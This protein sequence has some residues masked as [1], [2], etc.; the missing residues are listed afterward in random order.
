MNEERR[1]SQAGLNTFLA[2][3]YAFMGA[4]VGVSAVVAFILNKYYQYE[5]LTFFA[6]HRWV[7]W[8]L[9]IAQLAIAWT[10]SMRIDRTPAMTA[11]GLF[12]FA[13]IEGIFFASILTLYTGQDITMAFVAAAADF[14]VL[15]LFGLNTKKSLAGVGRQAMAALIALIIVS[16]INLFLQSTMIVFV[17]SIIGVVIFSLLTAWDSQRMKALY[18]ANA[19][20]VNVTNLAL[21][22]A[23]QLYLDFIN[24]FLQLLQIFGMGGDRK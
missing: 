4:A 20:Q 5:M 21:I 12:G 11:V 14:I 6:T 19:G 10:T 16:V 2:K 3:M 9:F 7:M 24:L 13:A 1:L 15:A 18:M 22:G 17:F 23:F 8:A